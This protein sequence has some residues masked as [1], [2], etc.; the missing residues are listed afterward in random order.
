MAGLFAHAYLLN[1]KTI[2]AE[3][4]SVYDDLIQME[5]ELDSINEKLKTNHSKELIDRQ[6]YLNDEF[7]RNGGLTYKSMTRSALLGLGFSEDD[8]DKPTSKLSGGQKSK[9]ILAKLLLSKA[10]F[11]LLDEPTNHLDIS[12]IAWL[13]DFLRNFNGACLIISHDRYF[14]DRVTDKTIELENKKS[15]CSTMSVDIFDEL[16]VGVGSKVVAFCRPKNIILGRW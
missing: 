2:W 16:G 11:L 15:V 9:L 10:D 7:T 3:L 8:F 14:L 1:D 4:V 6:E 12:A 5:I 13:E